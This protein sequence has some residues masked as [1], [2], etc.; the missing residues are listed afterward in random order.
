MLLEISRRARN[1]RASH[2]LFFAMSE[3]AVQ[4]LMFGHSTV[5]TPSWGD[6]DEQYSDSEVEVKRVPIWDE[7][8]TAASEFDRP[9]TADDVSIGR[10]L[11]SLEKVLEFWTEIEAECAAGVSVFEDER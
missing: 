3:V 4:A 2:S 9:P 8:I 11:D 5:S 1:V 7:W 10:R 6:E